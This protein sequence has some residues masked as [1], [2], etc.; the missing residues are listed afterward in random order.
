MRF[1]LALLVAC[2]RPV[3]A[4]PRPAVVAAI[5]IDAADLDAP[6]DAEPDAAIED[7]A[8]LAESFPVDKQAIGPLRIGM[9]EAQVAKLL[10]VPK[11]K[12]PAEMMAATGEYTGEWSYADVSLQM[13]SDKPRGPFRVSAI[14]VVAPSRYKTPEGIGIG[15]TR[16]EIIAVYG[17]YLGHTNDANE[18]LVGSV[19]FGLLFT[20]EEERVAGIFL[21]AMAF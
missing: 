2:Q 8:S 9:P 21:G 10:G 19:Y 17:P 1:A 14:S 4:P 3:A 16:G 11:T 20:L 6:P 5:P 15:A 12:S 18:M 13:V 7:D